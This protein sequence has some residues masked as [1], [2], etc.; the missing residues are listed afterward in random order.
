MAYN[1]VIFG[2]TGM[3]GTYC[4][5][6]L[7][8]NNNVHIIDRNAYD[9]VDNDY[10]KL[11]NIIHSYRNPIIINCAGMIP[12]RHSGNDF[13][14]FIVNSLFPKMLEKIA[15]KLDLQF[16]HM[17]TNC[18]FNYEN[19]NN[20][21]LDMPNE[22]TPYGLSKILGEPELCT[23]IR[24]SI[25][26]EEIINKKSFLEWV[27][28]NK[29]GKINGY[30]NYFWNGCTCLAVATYLEKMIETNSYWKGIKHL[31]SNETVSKY[32]LACYVNEIY[33]LDIEITPLELETTVNKTLSSIYDNVVINKSIK[34]QIMEQKNVDLKLGT[35]IVLKKCRCCNN[36]D[37]TKIW[38]IQNVPLAGGFLKKISDVIYERHY[39]LTLLYCEEC[40]SAFVEEIVKE[41]QLFTNINNNG[42]FYYS[43]QIPALLEHFKHLYEQVKA[44]YVL[45]GKNLL[46]I[47]CNDGVFLNNFNEADSLKNTIGIDPSETIY[48]ITN[49]E[50]IKIN[51]FFN[52]ET[53]TQILSKYGKMDIVVACNCLAH[54]DDISDIFKNLKLLLN[55]NGVIIMEVHY[56]KNIC[57]FLNFDFIYHEHMSYYSINGI[58]NICKHNNLYLDNIEH[59]ANH[60][61]SIRIT[62]KQK[63]D[64]SDVY[65][66]PLLTNTLQKE[67]ITVYMDTLTTR[68]DNW[69]TDI[70]SLIDNVYKKEHII[71]G[72]GASGRTTILMTVMQKKFDFIFDDSISKINNLIPLFHTQI[73]NSSEIYNNNIKTVFILAW[74]YSKYIMQK[75]KQFLENGGRFIIILPVI[76]EINI[77]NYTDM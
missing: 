63:L 73:L 37:L 29:N 34:E 47:G 38:K 57:E 51:D 68:I 53:T 13:N 19:G 12:Q 35:Y 60:G 61:G 48:A 2:G 23:V 27:I 21:E 72:Y 58:Y 18:V 11:F 49:P 40:Y 55:D 42:Y 52:S 24:T 44:N 67:A 28:S 15:I 26:G 30:N 22:T 16:I 56:V 77:S 65:H 71:A 10:D 1:I 33:E 66:N 17:S 9:I 45:N 43:S 32:Q 36:S 31:Y 5:N 50:I 54:I 74:P 39:P 69:K 6:V 14:Y 20:N 7:Q 8:Q 62:I 25:I 75:H 41:N 59:I 64:D 46:E 70:C 4:A 3:L 76:K